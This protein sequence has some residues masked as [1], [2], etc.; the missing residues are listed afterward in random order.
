MI[1]NKN[2]TFNPTIWT[3]PP[4]SGQKTRDIAI[5]VTKIKHWIEITKFSELEF[6]GN[7]FRGWPEILEIRGMKFRGWQKILILAEIKFHDLVKKSWNREIFFP[8][9]FLTIK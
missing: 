7:K 1:S 2:Q 4:Y 5:Y 8:R 6:R 3:S 9:K